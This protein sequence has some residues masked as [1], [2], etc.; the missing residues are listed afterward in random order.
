METYEHDKLVT[1]EEEYVPAPIWKRLAAF[2]IDNLILIIFGFLATLIYYLLTETLLKI[3]DRVQSNL[4]GILYLMY[5]IVYTVYFAYME[6]KYEATLGKMVMNI[7]VTDYE[8]NEIGFGRSIIRNLAKYITDGSFGIGYILG[9]IT[10]NKQFL[11]DF[12]AKTY[13][14]E[15]APPMEAENINETDEGFPEAPGH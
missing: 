2:L 3:P 13:V 10:K 7:F 15:K 14:V 1:K 6:S 5:I 8:G 4:T 12:I 11:H 9:F